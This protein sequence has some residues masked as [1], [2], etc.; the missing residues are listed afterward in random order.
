MKWLHQGKGDR[1]GLDW[2]CRLA[3]RP[4][5]PSPTLRAIPPVG[6]DLATSQVMPVSADT[7]FPWSRHRGEEDLLSTL[8]P[9]AMR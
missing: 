9:G 7:L 4:Q 1:D 3:T 2:T 8:G 6:G 5:T